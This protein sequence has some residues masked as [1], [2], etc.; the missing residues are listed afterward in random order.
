MKLSL[1]Q[2]FE[3]IDK[4][5]IYLHKTIGLINGRYKRGSSYYLWLYSVQND[6]DFKEIAKKL[7]F[8][9]ISKA[10]TPL[11]LTVKLNLWLKMGISL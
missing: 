1:D 9:Q 6:I 8:I 10:P 2:I 3:L 5:V 7:K 11:L 4:V